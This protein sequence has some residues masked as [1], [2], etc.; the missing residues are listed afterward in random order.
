MPL[1]AESRKLWE[2]VKANHARLSAC[3]GPHDWEVDPSDTYHKLDSLKKRR[4]K[5]CGGVMDSIHALI[6]S[7]G[8]EHGRKDARQ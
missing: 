3:E 1:S 4:C 8:V 5:K 7:Q 6:Y 2:E